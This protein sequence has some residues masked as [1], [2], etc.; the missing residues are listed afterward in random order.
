L[1]VVGTVGIIDLAD[2]LEVEQS[3]HWGFVRIG[4]EKPHD[5][6]LLRLVVGPDQLSELI[7]RLLLGEGA[8]AS[9]GVPR[10]AGFVHERWKVDCSGFPMIYIPPLGGYVQLFPVTKPQVEY[11][12]TDS[13]ESAYGRDWYAELLRLNPRL[14]VCAADVAEFEQLF[15][16]GLLP[17]E[18][19]DF[20]RWQG[21]DLRPMTVY[22][23]R[24]A[25]QWLTS[26]P[27]SVWP[28][29]LERDLNPL[30]HYLWHKLDARLQP[31]ALL[32]LSLMRGGLVE[33][34]RGPSG[35][36]FGMGQPRQHFYP[37]FHDAL[38][39]DPYVPTSLNRRSRLFGM[40]LM[41]PA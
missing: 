17:Q 40:R 4:D 38:R 3:A 29:E 10:P 39:D 25:Y 33:W 31:V 22:E 37:T 18:V 23:W 26:A 14:S 28:A 27:L 2:W 16:T 21:R 8:P 7:N 12:L 30:A 9:A 41:Q 35:A 19:D 24:T 1:V 13:R 36:W 5:G 6:S 34:V 11:F 32:D 20:A 15:A